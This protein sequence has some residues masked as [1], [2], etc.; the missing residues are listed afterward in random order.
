MTRN[1]EAYEAYLAGRSLTSLFTRENVSQAIEQFER[2]VALDPD[3][4]VAW[5]ALA[6]V[7]N[8]AASTYIPERGEE[9]TKKAE[10]AAS[11]AIALAPESVASTLAAQ[12]QYLQHREYVAAEQSNKKAQALAPRDY[13]TNFLYALFLLQV[14]RPSKAVAYFQR[15]IRFS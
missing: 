8:L 3:F 13:Q 5:N 9:F 1:V 12:Q 2:A 11:R 10:A 7:C 4:A 14:G 15:A 6:S